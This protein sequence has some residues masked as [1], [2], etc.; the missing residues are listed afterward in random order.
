MSQGQDVGSGITEEY[1]TTWGLRRIH[2]GAG[3]SVLVLVD[4]SFYIADNTPS[5][6]IPLTEDSI[7]SQMGQIFKDMRIEMNRERHTH[8][9]SEPTTLQP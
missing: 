1:V 5:P 8:R 4:G 9:S 6:S 7:P 3:A 2:P